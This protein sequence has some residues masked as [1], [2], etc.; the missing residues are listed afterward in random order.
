VF[1]LPFH[2]AEGFLSSLIQLMGLVLDTPHSVR[3][4]VSFPKHTHQGL[5]QRI[6]A[7]LGVGP[8]EDEMCGDVVGLPV[9]GGLHHDYRRVA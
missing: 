1:H 3:T 9:L 4:V 7:A 6:P 2:Q 8:P 5:S